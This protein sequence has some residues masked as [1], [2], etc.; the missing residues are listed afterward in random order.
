MEYLPRRKSTCAPHL[1]LWVGMVQGGGPNRGEGWVILVVML[2]C[3][4]RC[5]TIYMVIGISQVFCLKKG[6]LQ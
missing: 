2:V 4:V 1:V 6:H 3:P 5:C